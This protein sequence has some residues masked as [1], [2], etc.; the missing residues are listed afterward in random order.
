MALHKIT[1]R[2]TPQAICPEIKSENVSFQV[3]HFFILGLPDIYDVKVKE[4]NMKNQFL[5]VIKK[6]SIIINFFEF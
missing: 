5:S 6:T 2:N 1:Y 4:K 3:F